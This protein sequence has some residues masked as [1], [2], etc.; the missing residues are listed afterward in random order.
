MKNLKQMIHDWTAPPVVEKVE[1]NSEEKQKKEPWVEVVS[2]GVDP[3]KG[4]H[5]K[6]DWNPE[7]VVYLRQHGYTGASEE[8][9]VGK[10]LVDLYKHI[11]DQ[12]E[13]QQRNEFE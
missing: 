9:V 2:D 5:M 7:F 3:I 13:G 11:S 6:L 10:W 8:T 12:I 1:T 4:I